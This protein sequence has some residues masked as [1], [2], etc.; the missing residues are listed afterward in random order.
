MALPPKRVLVRIEDGEDRWP[1]R[2]FVDNGSEDWLTVPVETAD[3]AALTAEELERMRTL[4]LEEDQTS[5]E[6]E[7]VGATLYRLLGE[8]AI[9]SAWEQAAAASDGRARLLMDI[10]PDALSRLPWEL[11]RRG[12]R[13]LAADIDSPFARVS[14]SFPGAAELRPVRWPLRVMVVVGSAP[15]DERVAAESELAGLRTAF[16]RMCGLLDMEILHQPSRDRVQSCYGQLRPHVFH[17]IGHGSVEEGRGQ[18]ELFNADRD[19]NVPWT[20]A[21]ILMDL[22][23]WQPRLAILNAC[24]STSLEE[25]VGAWR[26]AQAFIELGVPGVIAMQGDIKGEAGAAFT[27]GLYRSLVNGQP[28]DAAAAAGRAAIT[29]AGSID[30]RDFALPSLTV[31]APPEQVLRTCFAVP[32]QHRHS[33][34]LRHRKL[35]GFVDRS[36]ER[37]GLWRRI[38]PAPDEPE[39]D[40]DSGVVDAI[41]ILGGS[42][43]G[44]SELARWCV[45]TCQLHGGNAAYVEL[46]RDARLT[47]LHVL[48]LIRKE[49]ED[50]VVHGERNRAAFE[51]W[52]VMLRAAGVETGNGERRPPAPDAIETIFTTFGDALKSAAAES[53]V[54]IAL[55]HVSGVQDENWDFLCKLLLVPVAQH[56][57]ENVRFIIVLSDEQRDGWLSDDTQNLTEQVE[58]RAFKPDEFLAHARWYFGFHF[59]VDPKEVDDVM[60]IMPIREEWTWETLTQLERVVPRFGWTRS[61]S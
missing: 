45:G 13:A 48:H 3:I 60:T 46:S 18:L 25:Q 21:E 61:A 41:A 52:R 35:R 58:L 11:M 2:L 8:G 55:D 42:G 32:S 17:F 40:G 57:L 14:K 1:L 5:P 30:R 43:V 24:R 7:Q 51:N 20:S 50:S 10:R 37:R 28:L 31:S 27:G 49:L 38:D 44:K 59:D 23:G 16:R 33:V 4:V 56:R 34:E 19:E 36:V 26:V 22:A 53:P 29:R 6:F 47:F 12:P 54:L 15:D 39:A 9:G